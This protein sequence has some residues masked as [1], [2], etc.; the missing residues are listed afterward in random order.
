MDHRQSFQR[1]SYLLNGFDTFFLN[2]STEFF[3][4]A[5]ICCCFLSQWLIVVSYRIYDL[6]MTRMFGFP[7]KHTSYASIGGFYYISLKAIEV[8][9]VDTTGLLR[10]FV[11]LMNLFM[12]IGVLKSYWK[13]QSHVD[14]NNWMVEKSIPKTVFLTASRLFSLSFFLNQLFLPILYGISVGVNCRTVPKT[15]N[16]AFKDWRYPRQSFYSE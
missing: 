3:V 5:C 11:L 16:W 15:C 14:K 4:F 8:N 9:A 1:K 6:P 10:I 7:S 2:F 13:K 12:F